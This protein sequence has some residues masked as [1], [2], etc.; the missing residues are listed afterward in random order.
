MKY[1]ESQEYLACV[2]RHFKSLREPT[3]N[4]VRTAVEINPLIWAYLYG[5]A[6]RKIQN[7]T[8]ENK[9][10]FGPDSDADV[11]LVLPLAAAA[12]RQARDMFEGTLRSRLPK[13]S[14]VDLVVIDSFPN[15]FGLGGVLWKFDVVDKGE[16]LLLYQPYQFSFPDNW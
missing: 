4:A 10:V 6:S 3:E 16:N 7:K 14:E 13:D 11:A 2:E 8:G 9:I 12:D 15:P 5:S 1:V